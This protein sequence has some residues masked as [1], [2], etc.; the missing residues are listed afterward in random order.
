MALHLQRIAVLLRIVRDCSF[1]ADRIE[2]QKYRRPHCLTPAWRVYRL[3]L[4]SAE[5]SPR[6]WSGGSRGSRESF[7]THS[8][9][10]AATVIARRFDF[11]RETM[12]VMAFDQAAI[13]FPAMQFNGVL[14]MGIGFLDHVKT[15][16]KRLGGTQ[17]VRARFYA[18]S[19][20]AKPKHP[21][22]AAHAML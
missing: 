18:I 20:D 11:R 1:G 22:E 13:V 2:I 10:F 7:L 4:P 16:L 21:A 15:Q 9:P 14:R 12:R 6:R 8:L 3:A 5:Q 17:D 19:L